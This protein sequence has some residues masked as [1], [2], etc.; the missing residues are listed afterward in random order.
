MP[1]EGVHGLFPASHKSAE[2]SIEDLQTDV[3]EFVKYKGM[4]QDNDVG[5]S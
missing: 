4:D 1:F 2:H 5:N 3:T